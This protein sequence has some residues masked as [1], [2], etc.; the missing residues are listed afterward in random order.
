MYRFRTRSGLD[1]DLLCKGRGEAVELLKQIDWHKQ[2]WGNSVEH[3]ALAV[4]LFL[5]VIVVFIGTLC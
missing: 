4:G 5:L 3:Y 1:Q 2:Y